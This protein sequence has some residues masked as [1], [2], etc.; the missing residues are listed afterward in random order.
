MPETGPSLEAVAEFYSNTEAVRILSGENIHLGYWASGQGDATLAE[1]Q[2]NLT[3]LVAARTGIRAEQRLLDVGCGTGGP[4]RHITHTTR[5]HVT[6]ISL[7][8]KQVETATVLSHEEGLDNDTEYHVADAVCLPFGDGSF[9]AAIA[10]ES[11]LHMPDKLQALRE[12]HRVLRPGAQLVIADLTMALQA[13]PAIPT[14]PSALARS[15][16]SVPSR[17]IYRQ[18]A[19]EAGFHVEDSVDIS[20]QTKLSYAQL[21]ERL[22]HSR[23]ELI[24]VCGTEQVTAI[25]EMVT[26]HAA[27]ADVGYIGYLLLMARKPSQRP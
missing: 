21:L 8:A 9:D 18:L 23:N 17:D 19:S 6:G 22:T 16:V 10:I 2:E 3:D 27:A 15:L 4:A 13:V 25:E 20:E 5:A 12:I 11:I 14:P 26:W 7:S 24:A 1:A